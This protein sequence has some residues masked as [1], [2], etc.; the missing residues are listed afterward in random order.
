[1]KKFICLLIAL[2]CVLG[3]ISCGKDEVAEFAEL[4]NASSPTKITTLTSLNDGEETLNG[5]YETVIDGQNSEMS[6]RYERY[7]TVEE[8]ADNHIKTVEGT[9]YYKNGLYS[10]DGENWISATPDAAAQQVALNLD[11]KSLGEYTISKDG[12]TLTTTVTSEQAEKILGVNVNASDDKVT[13]TVVHN[14][15]Y[16][17]TVT[18]AYTTSAGSVTIDTSYTYTTVSSAE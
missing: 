7:A 14:G 13:I 12:K 16:L 5:K 8:A 18:V 3:L 17:S 6:Y 4:V 15:T 9:V 10:E 2:T 1:M 11:A